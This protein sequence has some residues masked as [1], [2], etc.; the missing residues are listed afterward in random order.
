MH[1]VLPG[2]YN[3]IEL[4][5]Q[6][7]LSWHLTSRFLLCVQASSRVRFPPATG[8]SS[9]PRRSIPCHCTSRTPGAETAYASG[10]QLARRACPLR[11]RA[12]A[13]FRFSSAAGAAQPRSPFWQRVCSSLSHV[14]AGLLMHQGLLMQVTT[15]GTPPASPLTRKDSPSSARS[16]PSTLG[17]RC[18]APSVRFRLHSSAS[19]AGSIV[20]ACTEAAPE[21]GCQ[22]VSSL[23]SVLPLL[24]S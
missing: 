23:P 19:G 20:D 2:P 18:W 13:P 4:G 3:G 16:R 12:V 22:P 1:C 10:T 17:G 7:S 6:V 21:E 9:R 5:G 15:A 11:R 24:S 8:S 14:T